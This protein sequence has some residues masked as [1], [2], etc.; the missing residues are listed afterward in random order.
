MTSPP[1][2]GFREGRE[3]CLDGNVRVRKSVPL[4]SLAW[5]SPA[6]V[7]MKVASNEQATACLGRSRGL[8]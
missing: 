4:D 8:S 7:D 3:R 5:P 1:C 2:S 6:V